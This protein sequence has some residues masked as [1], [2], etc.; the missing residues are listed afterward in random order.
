MGYQKS[1]PRGEPRYYPFLMLAAVLISFVDSALRA[2]VFSAYIK[3]LGI[4][5][6]ELVWM[7]MDFTYMAS[8]IVSIFMTWL[9]FD[10]RREQIARK[11]A[12]TGEMNSFW[13]GAIAPAVSLSLAVA[14]LYIG[15]KSAAVSAIVFLVLTHLLSIICK[16][17]FG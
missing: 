17:R 1:I 2:V 6:S 5:S 12:A 11:F 9:L 4:I 7:S 15:T 16:K 8:G 14:F 10:R 13:N 3:S